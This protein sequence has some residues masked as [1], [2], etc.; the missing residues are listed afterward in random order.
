MANNVYVTVEKLGPTVNG[1]AEPLVGLMLEGAIAEVASYTKH[2]VSM[3]LIKVLKHP[4]GYY[5]SKIVAD[6]VSAEMWSINDS[7]VI[8]GPWLEGIGSRNSPVTKF[9]GYAT[10]RRVQGRMSQ[11]ATSIVQAWVDRTIGRL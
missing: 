7:N 2:E 4:T 1:M 11:K 8:Y 3:E 10:F 5:E 9:A 6:P